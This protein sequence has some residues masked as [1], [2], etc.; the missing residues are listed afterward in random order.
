MLNFQNVSICT[1][2]LVFGALTV[3]LT[4][5]RMDLDE[6]L[7]IFRAAMAR[8]TKL[9]LS[10]EIRNALSAIEPQLNLYAEAAARLFDLADSN[11]LQAATQYPAFLGAFEALET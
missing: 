5:L 11:P 10:P 8:N 4:A 3:T 2:L 1:R 9:V 6:Q 7:S